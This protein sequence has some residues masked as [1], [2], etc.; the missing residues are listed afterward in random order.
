MFQTLCRDIF[1]QVCKSKVIAFKEAL[2]MILVS[3]FIKK[4]ETHLR[5]FLKQSIRGSR[6]TLWEIHKDNL[7]GFEDRQ[8]RSRAAAVLRIGRKMWR[9]GGIYKHASLDEA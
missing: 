5:G 2:K 9:S 3:G 6:M 8:G 4:I 1:Y 7:E